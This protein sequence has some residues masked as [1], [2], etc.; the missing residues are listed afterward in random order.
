MD[1]SDWSSDFPKH[2]KPQPL[3]TPPWL[4]NSGDGSVYKH[5]AARVN[6][7]VLFCLRKVF[8]RCL[9]TGWLIIKTGVTQVR[10]TSEI[11]QEQEK[12]MI[13]F[14]KVTDLTTVCFFWMKWC[15]IWVDVREC[16]QGMGLCRLHFI[17]TGYRQ[18]WFLHL[19]TKKT[20]CTK[21]VFCVVQLFKFKLQRVTN[22]QKKSA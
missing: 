14:L 8:F 21:L 20:K 9:K 11:S 7:Q 17:D 1:G 19:T 15:F 16:D 2:Y 4:T 22:N 12:R 13:F 3:G 10:S 6:T 18:K 5:D